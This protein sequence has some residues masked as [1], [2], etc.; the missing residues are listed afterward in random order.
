MK[1]SQLLAVTIGPNS[2]VGITQENGGA[3][4]I[5][6]R[7]PNERGYSHFHFVAASC[8]ASA[9][10][11]ARDLSSVT[12]QIPPGDKNQVIALRVCAH[13]PKSASYLIDL[14][15][16]TSWV[17]GRLVIDC[18]RPFVPSIGAL[19]QVSQLVGVN[20]SV[21][22]SVFVGG[23]R[24]TSCNP[25]C[26]EKYTAEKAKRLVEDGYAIVP[27]G[28]LL[29]RLLIGEATL[30]EV[31]KAV[32]AKPVNV[33]ALQQE[34][35]TLRLEAESLKA[36]KQTALNSVGE[37]QVQLQGLQKIAE[38]FQSDL[39]T[40]NQLTSS[41]VRDI[42][43]LNRQIA[44]LK[45]ARLT[46]LHKTIGLC[47]NSREWGSKTCFGWLPWVALKRVKAFAAGTLRDLELESSVTSNQGPC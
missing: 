22:L 12:L 33:A 35:A 30:E 5:S 9:K 27:D 41:L 14:I 3:V 37:I 40:G 26:N 7:Y 23:K 36:E 43:T 11:G 38:T 31:E 10:S 8:S 16:T 45:E 44:T 47:V 1:A 29:C 6:A 39:S 17:N 24:F 28:N 21:D 13:E 20:Y 46:D 18:D 15:L 42:Q 25:D 2:T 32:V 34:L 4:V 19:G